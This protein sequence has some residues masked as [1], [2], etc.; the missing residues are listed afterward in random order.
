[1]VQQTIIHSVRKGDSVLSLARH[2]LPLTVFMTS[3]ELASAIRL[4][5]AGDLG[6]ALQPGQRVIIPGFEAMPIVERPVLIAKALEVRGIYL[7]GWMAGSEK[8]LELIRRWRQAGGDA[9]VF[10]VKDFDGL[11]NVPFDHHLVPKQAHILIHSLPKFARFLHGLGL[12]SIARIA[13]FR[14]EFLVRQHPELAVRSRRSGRPW[15]ENGKL[16]WTDPSRPEVQ[17]YNIAL[18]RMAATSGVDEIQFDYVRFPA[19]GDQ[20]DV[21][22]KQ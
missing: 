2:Y 13:L 10:D 3:A 1:M 7:T 14:D 19:E 15:C 21:R 12:H 6:R 5:N 16:V 9:V 22:S 20:E 4:A 17:E 11:V 18:A 8:G